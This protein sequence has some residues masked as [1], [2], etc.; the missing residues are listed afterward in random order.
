VTSD[1]GEDAVGVCRLSKY[2]MI[3]KMSY[4]SVGLNRCIWC[5]CGSQ[6][7][8]SMAECGGRFQVS[9]GHTPQVTRAVSRN[10]Y[11]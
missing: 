5:I 6:E 10:I 4:I 1:R 2:F 9:A 7:G 3:V 8:T 11:R